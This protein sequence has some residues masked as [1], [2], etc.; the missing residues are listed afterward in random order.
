MPECGCSP[1][2]LEW[3][4]LVVEEIKEDERLQKLPEVGRAH[5]TGDGSVAVA[6]CARGDLTLGASG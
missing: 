2:T 5:Q 6:P 1:K 3:D 4:S